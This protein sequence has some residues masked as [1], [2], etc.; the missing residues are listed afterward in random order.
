MLIALS[1]IVALLAWRDW[2]ASRRLAQLAGQ[3]AERD[4]R[5]S[6]FAELVAQAPLALALVG[7]GRTVDAASAAFRALGQPAGGWPQ[8]DGA[9]GLDA[10]LAAGQPWSG[11]VEAGPAAGRRRFQATVL[12]LPG[13]MGAVYLSDLTAVQAAQEAVRRLEDELA[14]AGKLAT[15]GTLAAGIA[16]EINT[17]IQFI[18][19]NLHFCADAFAGRS[20]ALSAFLAFRA[21]ADSPALA[22]ARER[23]QAELDQVD[24]EFLNAEVPRS[25]EQS[26]EGV[27]R[28]ASIV[29]AMKDFSHPDGNERVPA[30]LNQAIRSTL[31]VARNEYKYVAEAVAELDPELPAV[32]CFHGAIQQVLLNLVVNAAHAVADAVG[33]S[34]GR[35]CITITT[36]RD[37]G[38]AEIRV[39][40]T[41][42]GIPEAV[43][44]RMFEPFFTTKPAGKGTG[45]GLSLSRHI[46][47][48]RHQGT[49]RFE[50][51][52]GKGTVFIIRLPLEPG[53]G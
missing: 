16:H 29:R 53:H 50:T 42:T 20:R 11:S 17:P 39:A 26:Q 35:G 21:E 2:A 3:L 24:L 5:L 4:R 41:G 33:D 6:A 25:L 52:T 22:E 36:R 13:G 31:I 48:Q 37:G 8:L 30:D 14:R 12:P 38:F 43:R 32:P 45:Q 40:D 18:G 46:I 47:E 49:I 9:S 19:D 10:A 1:L 34:G 15:L 7:P 27:V 23:L 28:V 51:A 44:P